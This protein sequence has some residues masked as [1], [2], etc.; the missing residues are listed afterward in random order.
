MDYGSGPY[1]V[2]I[3]A[4]QTKATFDVPIIDDMILENNEDFMLIID[5]TT[6]PDNV[7]RGDPGEATV[8]IVDNDRKL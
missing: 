7:T 3:P 4:G 8:N 5:E 1:I 2:M 6:L